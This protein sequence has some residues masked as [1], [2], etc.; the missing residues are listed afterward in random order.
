[1]TYQKTCRTSYIDKTLNATRNEFSNTICWEPLS[2]IYDNGSEGKH[3]GFPIYQNY[4]GQFFVSA[5]I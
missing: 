1:M 4:Y 5:P 2:R 3:K